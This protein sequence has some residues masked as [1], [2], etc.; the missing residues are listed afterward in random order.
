M[1]DTNY[2]L[3]S[4]IIIFFIN[5]IVLYIYQ[6]YYLNKSLTN[7]KIVNYVKTNELNDMTHNKYKKCIGLDNSINLNNKG[8]ILGPQPLFHQKFNHALHKNNNSLGWRNYYLRN[9]NKNLVKQTDNFKNSLVSN[10]LKNMDN[11][12]NIYKSVNY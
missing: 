11:V 4:V 1:N 5:L 6:E 9:N 10:Y 12:N 3:K 7:D 8:R 2:F